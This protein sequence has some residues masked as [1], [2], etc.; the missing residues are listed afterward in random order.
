VD[1]RHARIERIDEDLRVNGRFRMSDNRFLRSVGRIDSPSVEF[2]DAT[3]PWSIAGLHYRR[4]NILLDHCRSLEAL[5]SGIDTAR[6]NIRS[7]DR[8]TTLPDDIKVI[9]LFPNAHF[10]SG[11]KSTLLPGVKEVRRM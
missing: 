6:L 10:G 1:L 2:V 4:A 7:C 8:L 5:P 9:I 3:E 11:F